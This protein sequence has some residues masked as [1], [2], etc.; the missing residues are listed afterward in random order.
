[1][2]LNQTLIVAWTVVCP[3]AIWRSLGNAA[4]VVR[5]NPTLLKAYGVRAYTGVKGKTLMKPPPAINRLQ[6]SLLI[7]LLI[8]ALLGASLS[9]LNRHFAH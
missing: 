3:L 1:M 4:I 5:L 6:V 2:T 7:G 9:V 8:A